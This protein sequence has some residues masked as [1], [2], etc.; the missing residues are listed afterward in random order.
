MTGITRVSE[1][2]GSSTFSVLSILRL[3]T[4][5]TLHDVQLSL[6]SQRPLEIRLIFEFD[7]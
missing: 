5:N 7:I 4:N 6:L 2:E 3:Q 1:S